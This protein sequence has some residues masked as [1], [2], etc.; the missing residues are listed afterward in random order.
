MLVCENLKT[1]GYRVALAV[2]PGKK[3]TRRNALRLLRA[4]L[5]DPLD[6]AQI[7]VLVREEPA[8]T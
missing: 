7:E 4:I 5:K 1:S 8:L 6:L 3:S 2:W